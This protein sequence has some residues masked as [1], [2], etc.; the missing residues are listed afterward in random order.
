MRRKLV[1]LFL[2]I[3]LLGALMPEPSFAQG[4][5]RRI[6]KRGKN[7]YRIG[8]HGINLF[9][10][11]GIVNYERRHRWMDSPAGAAAVIGAGAGAGAITGGVIK[12]KKG[13][14][15]GALIGGGS[16]TALWLYKNRTTRRRIF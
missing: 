3:G 11:P 8:D 12:G 1:I 7:G 16:A 5:G 9:D 10:G 15:V 4:E 2:A 13:A 14:V 6:I